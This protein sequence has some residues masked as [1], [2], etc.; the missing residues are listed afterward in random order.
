MALNIAEIKKLLSNTYQR[1]RK[2]ILSLGDDSTLES[3]LKPLKI[4]DKVSPLEMSETELNVRGTINAEAINVGGSA[5][6]TDITE[7]IALND[8]SD[9]AYSSGDLTIASLD[10]I[11]GHVT[12]KIDDGEPDDGT[13]IKDGKLIYLDPAVKRADDATGRAMDALPTGIATYVGKGGTT[14]VNHSAETIETI[15]TWKKNRKLWRTRQRV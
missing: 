15:G 7:T 13:E 9:V 2:N 1:I 12:M 6:V 14:I 4:G 5:V 11:V 8:L 10:T 3:D